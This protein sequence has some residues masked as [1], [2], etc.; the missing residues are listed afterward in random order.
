MWAHN[1]HVGDVRAT[2]LHSAHGARATAT[3]LQAA[4]VRGPAQV[5]P[6]WSLGHLM[7]ET[8]GREA[9]YSIAS[10]RMAAV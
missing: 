6:K 5:G 7:R 9:V 3:D 2:E 8:F 4:T 10:Q 1:S